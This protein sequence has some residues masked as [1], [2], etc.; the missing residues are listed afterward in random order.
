[1]ASHTV[2]QALDL[3]LRHQFRTNLILV[4]RRRFISDVENLFSWSDIPFGMP[5]AIDAPLHIKSV[6]FVHQWHLIYPTMAGGTSDTFIHMDAVVEVD[7][8]G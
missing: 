6:D 5:M 2:S 1:M 7:K 8:V 4:R 3:V